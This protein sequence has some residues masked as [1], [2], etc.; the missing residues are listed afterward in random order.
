MP[1]YNPVPIKDVG[2]HPVIPEKYKKPRK[3]KR[4][5][6]PKLS[7]TSEYKEYDTKKTRAT[8]DQILG[9][10]FQKITKDNGA[11]LSGLAKSAH[12]STITA[13]SYIEMIQWIQDQPKIFTIKL[14]RGNNGILTAYSFKKIGSEN[15]RLPD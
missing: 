15:G 5:K 10:I 4:S 6:Y 1:P 11:T 9:A 14:N 13:R 3:I 2:D 7:P 12:I 8:P